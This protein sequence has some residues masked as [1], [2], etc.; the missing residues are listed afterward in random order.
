M[1]KLRWRGHTV[2]DDTAVAIIWLLSWRGAWKTIMTLQA[3]IREP[4]CQV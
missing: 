1:L 3:G 4:V 2:T